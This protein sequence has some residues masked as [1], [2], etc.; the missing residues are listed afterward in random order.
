VARLTQPPSRKGLE[1]QRGQANCTSPPYCFCN[2]HA[3]IILQQASQNPSVGIVAGML[4]TRNVYKISV[5]NIEGKRALVRRSD[6]N[7][8]IFFWIDLK[9]VFTLHI[10]L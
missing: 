9:N 1:P 7:K 5:L 10:P 8:F 3:N 2:I 6:W 4:E